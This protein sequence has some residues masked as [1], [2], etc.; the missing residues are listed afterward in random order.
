MKIERDNLAQ[1]RTSDTTV[2]VNPNR[3]EKFAVTKAIVTKPFQTWVS[4]DHIGDRT[5]AVVSVIFRTGSNT[6]TTQ[7]SCP[8]NPDLVDRILGV[9]E[10][11]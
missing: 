1:R 11:N 9:S 8:H 3:S 5:V 4:V 7:L 10:I 6:A 2:T